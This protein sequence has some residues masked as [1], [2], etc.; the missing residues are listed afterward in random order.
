VDPQQP[1]SGVRML[2]DVVGDQTADRRAQVRVLSALALLALLLAGV[3]IH[4]LLSFTV[5]QRDR[6]IGVRLALGARPKGIAGMIVSE[7]ARM[8][9][10]GVLAGVIVA[11]FAARAMSALLFGV[12]P[13]DPLTIGAAAGLCFLVTAVGCLR[14]A[15]RAARIAPMAALRAD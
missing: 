9:L 12:Q 3:G 4:G 13:D 15:V 10:F 6:E 8:A 11:Y 2:S 7:G 5:A 14:P 1:V